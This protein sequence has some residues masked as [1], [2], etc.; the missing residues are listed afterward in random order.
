LGLAVAAAAAFFLLWTAL[1]AAA[2]CDDFFWFDFG[3]LSPMMISLSL[4]G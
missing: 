3:D 1:V 4:F 2:F